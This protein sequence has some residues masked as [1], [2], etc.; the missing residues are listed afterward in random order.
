MCEPI[1][2][3][4]LTGVALAAGTA[5]QVKSSMDQADAQ[6]KANS[7][8]AAIQNR[9]AEIANIEAD[10]A[11]QRGQVAV[12]QHNMA[13]KGMIGKQRADAAG[14]GLLIDDGSNL[15][16][17]SDTAGY[18]KLDAMT[19][20]NNARREAWGYKLNAA[21]STASANLLNSSRVDPMTAGLSPLL[22]GISSLGTKLYEGK[23]TGLFGNT[24]FPKATPV[25]I[26]GF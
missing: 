21:N 17:V 10:Q 5:L 9:N 8:N 2:I 20:E 11:L 16:V 3:S 1:S 19:I 7:Y 14:S 26:P 18:G 22:S 15:D 24:G 6:N 23:Q 13:V 12:N 4:I 25:S